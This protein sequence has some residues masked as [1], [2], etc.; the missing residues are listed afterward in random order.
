MNNQFG[1]PHLENETSSVVEDI[2]Q[3]ILRTPFYHECMP[4]LMLNADDPP[5]HHFDAYP[6]YSKLLLYQQRDG[7]VCISRLPF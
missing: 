6:A 4:D 2:V 3:Q 5:V 1:N 7:L